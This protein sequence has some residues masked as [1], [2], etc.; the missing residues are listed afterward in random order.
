MDER[1][2]GVGGRG[3]PRT[4]SYMME[5]G[6]GERGKKHGLK[7]VGRRPP[8]GVSAGGRRAGWREGVDVQFTVSGVVE[9]SRVGGAS[10]EMRCYDINGGQRGRDPSKEVGGVVFLEEVGIIASVRTVTTPSRGIM[11]TTDKDIL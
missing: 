3:V 11:S 4:Q 5:A 6:G 10:Q 7:V 1:M 9:G 8:A 2:G